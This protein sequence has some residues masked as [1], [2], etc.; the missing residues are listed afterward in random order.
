MVQYRKKIA[1]IGTSVAALVLLATPAS[2]TWSL[3]ATD[4]RTG[5]VG[6]AIASC[7]PVDA[8]GDVS[9]PLPPVV[10]VPNK[11]AAATQAFFNMDAARRI[12]DLIDIGRS[13]E[14][15]IENVAT[16][17]FDEDF[18][19]R[20]HG[21]VTFSG[22]PAGF[23]GADTDS[24][25]VD[26]QAPSVS[27]QGNLLVSAAVIDN[28]IAAFE[29]NPNAPLAEQLLAGLVAGSEAGGDARC[30]D[31]TALFA[32]LVIALPD[33]DPLRP[34]TMLTV[35]RDVDGENPVDVLLAHY[36]AGERVLVDVPEPSTGG[37]F[38]PIVLILGVLMVPAAIV[39]W[40]WGYRK[41][42][43]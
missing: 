35:A 30:G 6:V 19:R 32:H 2:A 7:V 24:V 3:T 38:A 17:D 36:E 22:L 10:V 25:S 11:G 28:A 21:V 33:D 23:S 31:Q 42:R 8:L 41:P 1:A 13:P 14:E 37:L 39:F 18:E 5:E 15:I 34:S 12:R 29:L 16:E 20:Q 43:Y 40:R 4:Q 27:A 9:I 26:A